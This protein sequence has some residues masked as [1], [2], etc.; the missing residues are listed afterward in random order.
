MDPEEEAVAL[1]MAAGPLAERLQVTVVTITAMAAV[2]GQASPADP[3]ALTLAACGEQGTSVI[4][5]YTQG[6]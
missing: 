3:D 5:F 6:N 4:P 1:A 2:P